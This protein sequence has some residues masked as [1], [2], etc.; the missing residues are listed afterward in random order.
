MLLR[1][2]RA[3]A[4]NIRMVISERLISSEKITEVLPSV[5]D[6]WRAISRPS[7]DLPTAGLAA[8]TIILPGCNPLV[9]ESKS[10]KPV[11]TPSAPTPLEIASISSRACGNKVLS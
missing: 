1:P 4:D 9:S 11:L 7:V 6:A 8:S 10:L 3:S 5:I 2:T